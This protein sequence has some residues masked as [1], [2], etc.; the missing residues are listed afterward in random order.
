MVIYY[1][2]IKRGIFGFKGE[3]CL[4][5]YLLRY[6]YSIYFLLKKVITFLFFLI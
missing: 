2:G 6:Q 5:S 4:R 3:K 1:V